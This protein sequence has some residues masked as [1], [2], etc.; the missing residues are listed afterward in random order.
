M[1]ERQDYW[2]RRYEAEIDRIKAM[3]FDWADQHDCALGFA[4]SVVEV[5]TGA[6]LAAPYRGKYRT[7]KGALSAMKRAGFDRLDDMVASLLPEIH[8][9]Q[10]RIGD[11]ATIPADDAF[12]CTLGI[13]N[14]ERIFV[15]RPDG[16]GTVD[17]LDATRAFKVGT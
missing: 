2:R 17:L 4:A 5:L 13:V 14:G 16:L 9:S 8:V 7:A 6:D 12:G 11:V 15:M 3:P 1:L 10:A